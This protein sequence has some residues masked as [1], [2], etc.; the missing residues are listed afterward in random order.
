MME[1]LASVGED[2]TKSK[3]DLNAAYRV[4]VE[5]ANRTR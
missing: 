1:T 3:P 5:A 2:V 4:V